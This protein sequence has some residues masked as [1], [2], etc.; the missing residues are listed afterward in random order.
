MYGH[1]CRV[2]SLPK[3]YRAFLVTIFL[4]RV[5]G[6]YYFQMLEVLSSYVSIRKKISLSHTHTKAAIQLFSE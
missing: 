1:F 3:I 5:L 6:I 4:S 2:F